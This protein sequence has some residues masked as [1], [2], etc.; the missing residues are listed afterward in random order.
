MLKGFGGTDAAAQPMQSMGWAPTGQEPVPEH[1][2]LKKECSAGLEDVAR[3]VNRL[4]R[5]R[6][7][8]YLLPQI[9]NVRIHGPIGH[10]RIWPQIAQQLLAVDDLVG[11]LHEI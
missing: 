10:H 4:E 11:V 8:T 3:P 9:G 5:K 7:P 6:K 2:P 1:A